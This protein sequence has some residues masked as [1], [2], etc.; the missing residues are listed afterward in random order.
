MIGNNLN[1]YLIAKKAEELFKYLLIDITWEIYDK[2]DERSYIYTDRFGLNSTF[3]YNLI[4]EEVELQKL[5]FD[6]SIPFFPLVLEVD[7]SLEVKIITTQ[8]THGYTEETLELLK[9]MYSFLSF[10]TSVNEQA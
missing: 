2:Q 1:L 5:S 10:I 7:Y 6:V 3:I 9:S 8:G 4:Q